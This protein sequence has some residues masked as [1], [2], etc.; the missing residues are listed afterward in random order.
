MKQ[1][2]RT[3]TS[4][5]TGLAMAGALVV[6]PLL[7]APQVL[8]NETQTTCQGGDCLSLETVSVLSEYKSLTDAEKETVKAA[9]DKADEI[10]AQL[11]KLYDDKGNV[12]DEKKAEMLE[13]ELEALFK[14]IEKLEEKMAA[15]DKEGLASENAVAMKTLS[16]TEKKEYQSILATIEQLEEQLDALYGD[17]EEVSDEAKANG[18]EEQLTAAYEKLGKLDLKIQVAAI[19]ESSALSKEEKASLTK[20][21]QMI[22]DLEAQLDTC[23]SEEKA[24]QLEK[25]LEKVS[26]GIRGIED[27]YY[28]QMN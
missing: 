28:D 23:P 5:V 17:K 15:E 10:S 16:D 11:A 8:A 22:Y 1:T 19:D 3:L 2:K 21:Y 13:K 20:A 9:Y 12:T 24:A 18:L 25:E 7:Q 27:K 6:T 14:P 4:I 26:E